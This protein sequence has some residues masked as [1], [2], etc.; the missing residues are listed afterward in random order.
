MLVLVCAVI[1]S[2]WTVQDEKKSILEGELRNRV[3]QLSNVI[4]SSLTFEFARTP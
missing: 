1:T 2:L 3:L 4:S